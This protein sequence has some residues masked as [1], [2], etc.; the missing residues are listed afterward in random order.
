MDASCANTYDIKSKAIYSPNYPR[1]YP[2]TKHCNWIV[3][4]PIGYKIIVESFSYSLEPA[5]GCYRDSLKIHDGSSNYTEIAANLCGTGEYHG[6]TSTTNNLLFVFN[7]DDSYG[8]EGFQLK[9]DLIGMRVDFIINL[10]Q[11]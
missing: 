11:L 7:S 4:A 9:L 2:K 1:D 6:M 10:D 8:Y 5:T 3:A